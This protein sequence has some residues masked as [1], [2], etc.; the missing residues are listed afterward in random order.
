MK[1]WPGLVQTK[2]TGDDAVK[3]MEMRFTNGTADTWDL[4]LRPLGGG[5]HVSDGT[6]QGNRPFSERRS[7][8]S[9]RVGATILAAVC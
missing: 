2:E 6:Y 8:A 5:A 3:I 1:P 9:G 4:A 7:L